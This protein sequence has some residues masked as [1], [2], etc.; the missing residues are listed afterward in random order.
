MSLNHSKNRIFRAYKSSE[1]GC[2]KVKNVEILIQYG[3]Q[4]ATGKL[5]SRPP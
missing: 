3:A 4:P 2:T 1:Q 5:R